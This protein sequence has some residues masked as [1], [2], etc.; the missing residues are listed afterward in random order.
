MIKNTYLIVSPS[1]HR[2]Q[3]VKICINLTPSF[4]PSF[5][6]TSTLLAL[7]LMSDSPIL[8]HSL[9]LLYLHFP[10]SSFL[11]L[12]KIPPP[13]SPISLPPSF[14]LFFYLFLSFYYHFFS[15]LCFAFSLP[16][17]RQASVAGLVPVLL[18]PRDAGATAG[19]GE[20]SLQ[21]LGRKVYHS[22]HVPIRSPVIKSRARPPHLRRAHAPSVLQRPVRLQASL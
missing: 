10:T 4:K 12:F 1:F 19:R 13:P 22:A 14:Y 20:V 18:F 7:S 9:Q 8:S 11:L 15:L 5:D 6:I 16:Q 3:E 17:E 2:L 21:G